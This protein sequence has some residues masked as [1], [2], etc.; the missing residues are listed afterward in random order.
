MMEV[1]Q[2]VLLACAIYDPR[3][4]L[5]EKC[6]SE[7]LECTVRL[8]DEGMRKATALETCLITK[9]GSQVNK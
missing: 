9:A 8:E 6:R 5:A 2:I 4:E 1:I 7:L 3:P